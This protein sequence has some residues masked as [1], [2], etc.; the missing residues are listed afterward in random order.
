MLA[1]FRLAGVSANLPCR[2][3]YLIFTCLKPIV[4]I[5]ALVN[6]DE[7]RFPQFPVDYNLHAGIKRATL[8]LRAPALQAYFLYG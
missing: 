3:K 2:E 4:L 1:P 6:Y 7:P 8:S 5:C